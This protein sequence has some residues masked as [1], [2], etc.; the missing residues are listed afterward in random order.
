VDRHTSKPA[1]DTSLPQ[2]ATQT[3]CDHQNIAAPEATMTE[4]L[5]LTAAESEALDGGVHDFI[6]NDIQAKIAAFR[7]RCEEAES[8]DTGEVWEL[9]TEIQQRLEGEGYPIPP[10]M[11]EG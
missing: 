5:I 11:M 7:E 3:T 6:L 10:A 4:K 8:T 1:A 9:L 2:D